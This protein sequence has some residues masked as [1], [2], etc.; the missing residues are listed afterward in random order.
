MELRA[1]YCLNAFFK[2]Q[3]PNRLLRTGL[4]RIETARQTRMAATPAEA[5]GA[6]D[7][8]ND[9]PVTLVMEGALHDCYKCT[10]SMVEV[11]RLSFADRRSPS[12]A[13]VNEEFLQGLIHYDA[14]PDLRG[15]DMVTFVAMLRRAGVSWQNL[16]FMEHCQRQHAAA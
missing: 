1:A 2:R 15:P 7:H 13:R 3:N 11:L 5:A 4:T 14:L 9:F 12:M 6:L 8:A 16:D 10:D